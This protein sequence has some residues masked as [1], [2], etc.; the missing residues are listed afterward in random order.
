MCIYINEESVSNA[1]LKLVFLLIY[2]KIYYN[3]V[4]AGTLLSDNDI[5]ISY[6]RLI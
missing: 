2:T 6:I 1:G 3:I 4:Y 5:F